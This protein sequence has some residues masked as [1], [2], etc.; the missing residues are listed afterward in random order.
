VSDSSELY[1]KLQEM[2]I[3]TAVSKP[4]TEQVIVKP[5][6]I[7]IDLEVNLK[8][9]TDEDRDQLA[10]A[11]IAQLGIELERPLGFACRCGQRSES[12]LARWEQWNAVS[13]EI[14]REECAACGR[15]YSV[16]VTA[17]ELEGPST[18]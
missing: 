15:A 8:E 14:W 13:G 9:L 12:N 16:E 2:G 11:V 7:R 6:R 17:T 1:R 3:D 4:R 18:E 5:G 10:E